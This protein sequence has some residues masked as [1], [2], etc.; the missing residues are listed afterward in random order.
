MFK[1]RV[2][3][4]A[5]KYSKPIQSLLNYYKNNFENLED[6][7][8]SGQDMGLLLQFIETTKDLEGNI[9]ELGTYRG[10]STIMFSKFVQHLESEKR[11]FTCDTFSGFPYEDI[12]PTEQN[13]IG[14][15][16]DTSLEYVI[17]KYRKF[18][19]SD[20]IT[21]IKGKFEDTLFQK[22]SD[23]KFSFVLFDADLY[24]STKF[25]LEFVYPRLVKNGIM[26]FENYEGGNKENKKI[27]WGERQAVDEFFSLHNIELN[28][29]KSIPY[30]QK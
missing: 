16:K 29:E 3:R 22:L 8:L 5:K 7:I 28:T 13:R 12:D 14:N 26:A 6:L 20:R 21:V 27:L 18:N 10:G 15:L 11:I 23:Q 4:D 9:L 17:N 25:A 1:Y 30:F 2:K 24:Q 19:V